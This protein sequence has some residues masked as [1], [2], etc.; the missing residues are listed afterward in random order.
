MRAAWR[1][2]ERGG[3]RH[4][5]N[6]V[7]RGT[8]KSGRPDSNRRRPAWEAG[9]L[10]TELRPRLTY[11]IASARHVPSRPGLPPVVAGRLATEIRGHAKQ[12]LDKPWGHMSATGEFVRRGLAFLRA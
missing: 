9:I 10:P 2:R 6:G 1:F 12:T 11:S 4:A 3:A 7:D 8:K 5:E